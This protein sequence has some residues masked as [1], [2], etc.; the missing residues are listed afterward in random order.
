MCVTTL[1]SP[2][3]PVSSPIAYFYVGLLGNFEQ[4]EVDGSRRILLVG[5][6]KT[7]TK[8]ML[9]YIVTVLITS[10]FPRTL[11]W[12]LLSNNKVFRLQAKYI[13]VAW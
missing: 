3:Q 5:G 6:R 7:E 13:I 2:R 12:S 11:P 10:Q 8:P 4:E 1:D 9:A